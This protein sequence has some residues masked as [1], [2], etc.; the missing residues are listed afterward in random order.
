MVPIVR[1]FEVQDIVVV[2]VV[3]V[4]AQ[5]IL[6]ALWKDLVISPVLVDSPEYLDSPDPVWA[7]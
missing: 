2:G 7:K 5:A 6:V 4:L 1:P 3:G